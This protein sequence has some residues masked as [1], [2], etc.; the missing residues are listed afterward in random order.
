MIYDIDRKVERCIR[1]FYLAKQLEGEIFDAHR[2]ARIFGYRYAW[3]ARKFLRWVSNTNIPHHSYQ[4]RKAHAIKRE[5]VL[6]YFG[7]KYLS[8]LTYDRHLT[9]T[10]L[11]LIWEDDV[12]LPFWKLP[13]YGYDRGICEHIEEE[14]VNPKIK[15]YKQV[16]ILLNQ[17][18]EY[19]KKRPEA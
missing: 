12:Q 5:F 16:L 4:V 10:C 2:G 8:A 13:S 11:Y 14:H 7:E 15:N 17:I 6:E 1:G 18:K 3:Q 19:Y 9:G